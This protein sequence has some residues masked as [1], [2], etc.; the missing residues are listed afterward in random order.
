M[1]IKCL[2]FDTN[3]EFLTIEKINLLNKESSKEKP[4]NITIPR[5]KFDE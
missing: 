3:L 1:F 4:I 2:I 5:V